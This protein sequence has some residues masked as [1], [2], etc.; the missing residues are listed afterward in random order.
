M[1]SHAPP[2]LSLDGEAST[3]TH[4]GYC[5]S[6]IKYSIEKATK[7]CA[8]S[9]DDIDNT[10]TQINRNISARSFNVSDFGALHVV[11]ERSSNF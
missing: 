7:D 4:R 2:R 10:H 5:C 11:S 9:E 3:L 1:P 8:R 6:T